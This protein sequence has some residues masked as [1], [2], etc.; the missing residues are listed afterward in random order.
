M[1]EVGPRR[2]SGLALVGAAL[3]ALEASRARIDDLNVYPVP[4]GD[5]GTNMT[6]TVRAVAEALE[7]DPDADIG[8]AILMGARG[9]SGVILSQLVA[10]ALREQPEGE[11][12]AAA[13]ARVLRGASDAGYAAVRNPQEG[14]ILTVAR[15]LAERAEAIAGDGH[16]VEDALADVLVAGEKAL[17]RTTEQLDV[18]KQAGV[19]DAGG[20]GLIEI[21]RGIASHLRGEEL[22]EPAPLLEAIPLDAVHQ[23]LSQV[24]LLHV[25]LRRGRPAS[26]PDEL[27]EE[28]QKLGDSLLVVGAA[29]AVK[30]HVHTDEPGRA[31]ALATAVGVIEEVDVKNMHVQTVATGGAAA[32]A[33]TE[34]AVCGVVSVCA[35]AGTQ[36][37]F[38]SLGATCV[39]GGQSMN[40]STADIV[41][42]IEALPAAEAVVLPNNKNVI[43]AAEQAVGAA[44]KPARLVPTRSV[45]AGL[46]AMVSFD[47]SRPAEE[48]GAE[49]DEAAAGVRVGGGDAGLARRGRRRPGRRGG[50][51]PRP[52]R[53]RAGHV[54][55]RAA[56]RGPRPPGAPARGRPGR[57]HDPGR[58]GRR[59]RRRPRRRSS[60]RSTPS[61]RS[62]C[63]KAGSP[64]TPFCSAPNRPIQSPDVAGRSDHRRPRRGQRHL[65]RVARAPA[66]HRARR[67]GRRRRCR[68]PAA[69]S[70]SA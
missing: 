51:V 70:R 54:R 13:L 28:L 57:A 3:A 36:R 29:G 58:R 52:A 45:Q 12:D 11:I 53:G 23:E 20:A 9:N 44:E 31:L 39:E 26:I 19:V 4:D 47:P 48:N 63:T 37:L 42:A 6:L 49:M 66:Q 22:P 25:L 35:G 65:P 24:P 62:R 34:T 67:E 10:G 68:R 61:S 38:E 60:A 14:T 27:E 43:L 30:V 32:A 41:A 16:A 64:T 7:R 56:A 59:G 46:G 33:P 40:P 18:L 15:A 50:P 2:E 21:V 5:T 17:E 69:R 1:S 8:R 55:P